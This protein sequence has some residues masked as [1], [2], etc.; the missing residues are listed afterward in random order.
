VYD[1]QNI[2]EINY[3]QGLLNIRV[4]GN[5]NIDFCSLKE[6]LGMCATGGTCTT[7][8]TSITLEKRIQ[9]VNAFKLRIIQLNESN[10]LDVQGSNVERL[11]ILTILGIEGLSP[12]LPTFAPPVGQSASWLCTFRQLVG[13]CDSPDALCV[14]H[15]ISELS[16]AE[17]VVPAVSDALY[18]GLWLQGVDIS[19]ALLRRVGEL[20]QPDVILSDPANIRQISYIQRLFNVTL[21]GDAA[22][23]FCSLK[24]RLGICAFG[25]CT[26]ANCATTLSLQMELEIVQKFKARIR[27]LGDSWVTGHPPGK[28]E[29]DFAE[30]LL[31]LDILGVPETE[32]EPDGR[33][34]DRVG[35]DRYAT[36]CKFR[37]NVGLCG[38]VPYSMCGDECG[39]VWDKPYY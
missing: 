37:E 8:I 16:G 35:A 26:A 19:V 38:E 28:I 6:A 1:V 31:I 4:T 22:I 36:F 21:T 27:S 23:D 39:N 12:W 33:R 3:I 15:C 18:G 11:Q 14:D 34:R 30:R 2:Q 25:I 13:M 5:Y 32:A 7:C 10:P 17:T 9:L 20:T 29:A 24:E